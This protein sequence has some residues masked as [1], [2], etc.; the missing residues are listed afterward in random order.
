MLRCVGFPRGCAQT[1]EVMVL[2]WTVT[3]AQIDAIY[4]AEIAGCGICRPSR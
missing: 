2:F 1:R 4:R 3:A